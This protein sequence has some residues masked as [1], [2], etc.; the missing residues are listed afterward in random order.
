MVPVNDVT[1]RDLQRSDSQWTRAKG[2][3]TFCPVGAPTPVRELLGGL[4]NLVVRT[5]VDGELRQEGHASD[6]AFPI[7]ELLAYASRIMTLEAGDLISTGTPEG[8][9]RLA[10]GNV[11]RVEIEGAGSVEN[12]VE[13]G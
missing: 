10:P 4:E 1:A 11:V 12:P 8:V 6:M 13:F 7:P 3:D 9:G 5:F 2:C